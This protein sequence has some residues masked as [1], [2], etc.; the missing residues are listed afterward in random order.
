M[1]LGIARAPSH[2]A[3]LLQRWQVR[4]VRTTWQHEV[5]LQY[6]TRHGAEVCC[7]DLTFAAGAAPTASAPQ[8][9]V[10][11]CMCAYV[12]ASGMSCKA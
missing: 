10:H 6:C 3:H 8:F 1:H 5:G 9:C 2:S 4:A 7:T 11:A 12:Q